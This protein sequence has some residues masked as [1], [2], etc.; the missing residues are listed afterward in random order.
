[1]KK[2]TFFFA[3]LFTCLFVNAQTSVSITD[4]NGSTPADYITANS[5]FTH[6]TVLT[7]TVQY[8]NVEQNGG[9]P[10]LVLRILNNYSE[11]SG[12]LVDKTVTTS[13]SP[14]TTTFD[15]TVPSVKPG[16]DPARLQVRGYDTTS[17]GNYVNAYAPQF[18]IAE[19]P[20]VE[21][22]TTLAIT[23]I[24]GQTVADYHSSVGGELTEGDVLTIGIDYT[25]VK[26]D[27][28]R[29]N[30]D[31]RVR[32]LTSG[33]GSIPEGVI[34]TKIV[35]NSA[36]SQSTTV[37]IT[38]PNIETSLTDVRLQVLAYGHAAGTD[39]TLNAY[40]S[41][42]F[43]IDATTLSINKT[44]LKDVEVNNNSIIFGA[45][46]TGISYKIYNVTGQTVQ[47]GIVQNNININTLASGV[48]ILTTEKGL[49]KFMK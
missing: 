34:S 45:Q 5:P 38:V 23:T 28:T 43:N 22:N 6:S 44:T 49:L 25:A 29:D 14:Q 4:I 18:V 35:T 21:I 30:L 31:L 32:F 47:K 1:M 36:S 8:T 7:V 26:K 39:K 40:A 48:Y 10:N 3:L 13:A 27:P 33:Y 9:N 15:I 20:S 11:I 24:E 37:D 16:I 12:A 42:L 19:D 2:I 46:Y 41:S 17:G